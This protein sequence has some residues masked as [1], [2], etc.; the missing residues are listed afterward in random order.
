MRKL[1]EMF[2]NSLEKESLKGY[3]KSLLPRWNKIKYCNL[4]DQFA[5]AFTGKCINLNVSI[6]NHWYKISKLT[7][8]LKEQQQK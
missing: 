1:E 3:L 6:K 2:L 4:R 5:A 7:L 8:S